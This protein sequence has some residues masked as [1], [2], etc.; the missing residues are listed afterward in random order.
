[1]PPAASLGAQVK[2]GGATCGKATRRANQ[3]KL[4]S[5][6]GKNIPLSSS[7]KSLV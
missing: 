6:R 1:M 2:S 3:Q 7:G 5:A 4:S